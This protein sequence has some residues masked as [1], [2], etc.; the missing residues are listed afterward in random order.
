[1]VKTFFKIIWYNF[2]FP[3]QNISLLAVQLY[4]VRHKILGYS[5]KKTNRGEGVEYILLWTPLEYFIF[6]FPME[7]SDKEKLHP[8][9][10][11]KILLDPL[12]IPRTKTKIHGNSILFFLGRHLKL[13]IVLFNKLLTPWKFHMLFLWYP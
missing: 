6:T 5:R 13:H 2:L 7:I 1:M 3:S 8:W 4:C 12:E 9:K 11:Y 10:F